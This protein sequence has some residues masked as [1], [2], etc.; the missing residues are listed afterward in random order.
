MNK[1]YQQVLKFFV[2]SVSICNIGREKRGKLDLVVLALYQLLGK[3]TKNKKQTKKNP[4]PKNSPPQKTKT[5]TKKT[6][7][8]KTPPKTKTPQ[9]TNTL[10]FT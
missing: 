9:P 1:E 2:L 3:K 6:Q 4:K 7:T 8:N 5:Q 10:I